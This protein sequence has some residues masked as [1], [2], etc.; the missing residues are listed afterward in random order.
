MDPQ[1]LAR[2]PGLADNCLAPHHR[3]ELDEQGFTILPDIIDPDWRAE[4]ATLFDQLCEE[5][6]DQAGHEVN[7]VPGVRRLADLA[8]KGAAFD[9][10]YTH[11]VLLQAVWHVLQRP[12]RLHS[13]NGHDPLP[14]HGQQ[15]LHTDWG[16]ERSRFHVVNS[17][18]MLDDF[19]P[20]NGATRVVPGTHKLPEKLDHYVEDRLAPRD[21][22]VQMIAPAGSVGIFNGSMWHSCRHNDS[23]QTRRTL[24]VAFIARE[25]AQQTD[26]KKYLRLQ[27]D[28]RIGPLGRYILDV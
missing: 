8:N 13:L 15:T 22:E 10:T 16:G 25:H 3:D 18:W 20:D 14:G 23:Q 24:H 4:L 6:G 2:E 17:M 19:T 26:Q 28:Q 12:F 9:R 27:T 11:P 1:I 7:I 21:D 5:E